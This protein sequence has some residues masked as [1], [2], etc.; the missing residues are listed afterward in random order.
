MPRFISI[1]EFRHSIVLQGK[2]ILVS[3]GQVIESS[4][5]LNYIFLQQVEDNTPVTPLSDNSAHSIHNKINDLQKEKDQLLACNLDQVNTIIAEM[6]KEIS[7]TK[8]EFTKS[9]DD[10]TTQINKHFDGIAKENENDKKVQD[11]FKKVVDRR[12]GILKDAVRTLEDEM[13]G[14]QEFPEKK[15]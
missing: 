7:A 12:L 15:A 1:S 13:F 14:P 10:L 5:P 11:E 8:E 4:T 9:L 6:R 2:K 3:P